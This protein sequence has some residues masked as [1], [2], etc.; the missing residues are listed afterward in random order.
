[1]NFIHIFLSKHEKYILKFLI[2]SLKNMLSIAEDHCELY[3]LCWLL[4]CKVV[5]VNYL[6]KPNKMPKLDTK[7]LFM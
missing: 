4:S 3:K 1:M 5:E 7:I 6:Y 2:R